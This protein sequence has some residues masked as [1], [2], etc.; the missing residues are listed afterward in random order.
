MAAT[1]DGFIISFLEDRD[2][3]ED[4]FQE[5]MLRLYLHRRSYHPQA[6]LRTWIYSIAR[7]LCLNVLDRQKADR[8]APASTVLDPEADPS[9][10]PQQHLELVERAEAVRKAIRSLP[11]PHREVILLARFEGLPYREVARI[12]GRSEPAVRV[13]AHR[14]LLSLKRSLKAQGK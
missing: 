2:Q 5:T 14:A 1:E 12:V 7:H 4:L 3:A 11:L 10:N 8:V 13:M 6:S 9:P